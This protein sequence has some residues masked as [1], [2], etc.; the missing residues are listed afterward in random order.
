MKKLVLVAAML[1]STTAFAQDAAEMKK[2]ALA[3]C[4]A[5]AAQIP[6]AQRE[7]VSK[8]C[9]CGAENTDYDLML[10][11]QSNDQEAM[12]M[13]QENAMKVGEKCAAMAQG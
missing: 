4:D 2:Q 8:M 1:A 7:M 5:Q 11:A 12:K 9:K 3:A 13:A 6:E 10:K